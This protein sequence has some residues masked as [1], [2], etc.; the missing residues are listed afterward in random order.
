MQSVLQYVMHSPFIAHT[1]LI[2]IYVPAVCC[3]H[4]INT[5]APFF[6]ACTQKEGS[7]P[8]DVGCVSF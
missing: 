3:M 2:Q 8:T 7:A 5:E 6:L 1:K 4:Y